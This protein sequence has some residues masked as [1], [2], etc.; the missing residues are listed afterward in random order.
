MPV[1]RTRLVSCLLA[2]AIAA[3]HAGLAQPPT[4]P[5]RV[6]NNNLLLFGGGWVTFDHP[7]RDGEAFPN[8]GF[9]RRV[10]R[11]ESRVLHLWVRGSANFAA[12]QRR[13]ASAYPVHWP[14]AELVGLD[15]KPEPVRE[16]TR[17]FT[18][19]AEMIGDLLRTSY[20]AIYA[21]AGVGLHSLHFYSDGLTTARAVFKTTQTSLAPSFL[22]GGRLF[23]PKRPYSA[24]GEV[25]FGR[26]YGKTDALPNLPREPYLTD[27]TFDFTGVNAV[28]FEGGL[29]LHW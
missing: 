3:P 2:L 15:I 19:R 17:D 26:A 27:Q 24:Y 16:R 22:A 12:E 13:Y 4:R 11:R 21:G 7:N 28:S 29:G 5:I 1:Q 6:G 9:Q 25:R 14:A 18:V 10:L 8:L 23:F 20:S